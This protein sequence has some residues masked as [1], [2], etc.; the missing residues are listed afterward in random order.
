MHEDIVSPIEDTIPKMSPGIWEKNSRNQRLRVL[1]RLL[2][3]QF[4]IFLQNWPAHYLHSPTFGNTQQHTLHRFRI[5]KTLEKV[6][7]S[8]R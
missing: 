7:Q 4:F 5:E 2:S 6:H 8:A 1:Q 3:V